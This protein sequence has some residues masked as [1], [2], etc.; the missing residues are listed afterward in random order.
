VIY[1]FFFSEF[2]AQSALQGSSLCESEISNTGIII[3]FT[4]SEETF[5]AGPLIFQE[6][7]RA[8]GQLFGP[9]LIFN[10]D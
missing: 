3:F 10:N 2:N 7:Q 5:T 6:S 1:V 4:L 9:L 8:F